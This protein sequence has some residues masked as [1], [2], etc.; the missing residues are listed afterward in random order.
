MCKMYLINQLHLLFQ[1]SKDK[2]IS[3]QKEK[4]RASGKDADADKKG[5]GR[6]DIDEEDM[7]ESYFK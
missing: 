5:I 4:D 7:Q 6:A 3:V 2:A 1:A